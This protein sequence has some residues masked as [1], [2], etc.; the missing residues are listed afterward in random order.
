MR[1]YYPS[2]NFIVNIE[3]GNWT[4]ACYFIQVFLTFWY[5]GNDSYSLWDW[6]LVF[7]EG[8]V[9]TIQK[10]SSKQI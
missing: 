6:E 5:E 3:K 8:F 4:P 10:I 2:K 9:V 1:R 7:M